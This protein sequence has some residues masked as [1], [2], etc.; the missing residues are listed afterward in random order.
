MVER[1]EKQK[2]RRDWLYLNNLI[3]LKNLMTKKIK[4]MKFEK[5]NDNPKYMQGRKT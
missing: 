4:I 2:R 1:Q 3:Q 5:E